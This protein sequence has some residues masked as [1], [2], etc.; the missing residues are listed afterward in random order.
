MDIS[1]DPSQTKR[2]ALGLTNYVPLFAG[3][4][5]LFRGSELNSYL[6]R[7]YDS[8]K[9]QNKSFYGT[10]N[11]ILQNKMGS[12]YERIII[13]MVKDELVYRYADEG[14]VRYFTDIAIKNTA[15]ERPIK[16]RV[17]LVNWL[18]ANIY[19]SNISGEIDILDD[20]KISI[21]CTDDIEAFIVDNDSI[22]K[23]TLSAI[24]DCGKHAPP[25]FVSPLPRNPS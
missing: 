15:I 7:E 22:E 8:P 4:Y 24:R 5:E 17:N 23:K 10:L 1:I 12:D 19:G 20:G 2:E 18:T 14:K 3:F 21:C 25:T 9:V 11:K 6:I 13:L 16:S